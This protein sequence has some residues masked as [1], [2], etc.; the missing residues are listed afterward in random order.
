MQISNIV[1]SGYYGFNNAGDEAMLFSIL[2]SL[3]KEYPEAG[4]TV[5][6]GN[7]K[8]TTDSFN[9]KSIFRF[10]MVSIFKEL[11]KSQL[12]ISGGGSLLQDVTSSKSILYYLSIILI[13]IL[14]K[15]K[16]FL[17]AQGIGPVKNRFTKFFL[18]WCLLHVDGITVR[19]LESYKFLKNLGIKKK[20]FLTADAVLS[21]EP[22][23]LDRGSA[24]LSAKKVDLKVKKIGI[25]VRNWNNSDNWIKQF[26]ILLKKLK[27]YQIIF[28]P[29]QYPEDFNIGHKIDNLDCKNIFHLDRNY[30]SEELM[31]IIGNMDLLIGVRLHALIFAT[32]MK[33]PVIGISYDPKIDNFLKSIKEN[34]IIKLSNFNAE[35]IYSKIIKKLRNKND[36]N[37][38]ILNSLNQKANLTVNLLK[39]VTSE[40]GLPNEHTNL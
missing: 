13:G 30:T 36:Y 24:I 6:S 27:D 20:L 14:C 2:R 40:R 8:N 28:I 10:K 11:M 7:P 1:I 37:I 26:N 33:V 22:V 15:C 23:L 9:V 32:I 25:C 17:Y 34:S 35:E 12:L 19:D 3:K 38:E 4:I 21:L 31:S 16:V 18:K 39:L 5:I 29:M